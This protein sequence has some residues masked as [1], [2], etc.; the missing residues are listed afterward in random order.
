MLGAGLL[1][2]A[3]VLISP[4]W[5]VDE[6]FHFGFAYLLSATVWI[7]LLLIWL[8]SRHMSVGRLPVLL[9]PLAMVVGVLPVFFPGAAFPLDRQTPFFVP[10]LVVGTLA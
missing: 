3:L 6:V 8:E 4:W 5:R 1:A 9:A 10:H 7:A 2:H